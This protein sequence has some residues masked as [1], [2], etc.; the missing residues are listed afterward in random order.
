[1]TKGYR[2]NKTVDMV[3][4]ELLF[5]KSCNT[6]NREDLVKLAFL[7]TEHSENLKHVATESCGG[8]QQQHIQKGFRQIHGQHRMNEIDKDALTNSPKPTIVDTGGIFGE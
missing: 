2:T 3:N 5:H 7:H 4:A 1:M 8:R 6:R